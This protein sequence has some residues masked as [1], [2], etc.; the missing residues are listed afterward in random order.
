MCDERQA[1]L[2]TSVAPGFPDRK[3]TPVGPAAL[4]PSVAGAVAVDGRGVK[5]ETRDGVCDAWFVVPTTG[6]HPAVLVWPDVMGPRPAF[7][8][9]AWRLAESGYAV[10]VVNPYYRSRE[11]PFVKPGEQWS[12]PEVRA[13]ITPWRDAL[14]TAHTV[15]DADALVNWLDQQEQV[16]GRRGM[17]SSGYCGGG[18]MAMRTAAARPDRV[19]AGASFHGAGLAT[20]EPDSPHLLVAQM[21]AEFLFAIADSDDQDNPQQKDLV[22]AAFTAA[23]LPAEIEV[24]RGTLHGWCPPDNQVHNKPRAE[25]AW[26]R[27]RALLQR[28][29][30][31]TDR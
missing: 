2:P 13:R 20:G 18:A 9:M 25:Q 26:T 8:Q 15:S 7:W 27:Q 19:R 22:R 16:D 17:A 24:Y 30:G 21:R 23:G 1:R 4:P 3:A 14:T 6:R 29:L 11:A 10:L 31:T 12:Q 5:I 28:A